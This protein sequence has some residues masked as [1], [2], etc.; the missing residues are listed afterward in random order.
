VADYFQLLRIVFKAGRTPGAPPSELTPG[1]VTVIVGPNNSGKS[2]LL[3]ELEQ[4]ASPNEPPNI[5]PWTPGLVIADVA[6]RWP[7]D[8]A[9]LLEAFADR[10]VPDGP[11]Q[12]GTVR[13]YNFDAAGQGQGQAM[14][15]VGN[16]WSHSFEEFCRAAAMRYLRMRFGW[17][18]AVFPG[19]APSSHLA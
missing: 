11:S 16:R 13:I 5:T 2:L 15:Y 8:E 7:P 10:V 12:D 18:S 1:S 17:A 4:W 9:A 19:G 6:A 14:L 3:R